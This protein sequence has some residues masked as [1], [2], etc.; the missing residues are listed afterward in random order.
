MAGGAHFSGGHIGVG[1]MHY[2]PA[3]GGYH[4]GYAG[5]RVYSGSH[6][7]AAA[8]ARGYAHAPAGYYGHG[9]Y[10]HG[11]YG[12]HY[13]YGHPYWGGGYWHGVYWPYAYYGWYY[14]WFLPVLPAV[15]ATYWW[16]GVPYY[17]ANNV[18]YTY[19]QGQNGYVVTDPPP[20]GAGDNTPPPNQQG[21]VPPGANPGD[22][23]MYPKN[24]Q[25]DQQQ[26]TDRFEC[27]KWAQGQ[28]GFDPS[29]SGSQGNPDDYHRAMVA[30]L[31]GRGYSVQ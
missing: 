18:Y 2:A 25:T 19:D 30:C 12:G 22:V 26:S 21:G 7:V 9:A 5:A 28:T 11:Y 13:Y 8:G 6:Y 14:P 20:S 24:G 15:Y 31:E 10:G 1:G 29:Q 27:H 3:Y 4:A 17:Y 16:G 23:F